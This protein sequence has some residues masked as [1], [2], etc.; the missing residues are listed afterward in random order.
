MLRRRTFSPSPEETRK[1]WRRSSRRGPAGRPSADSRGW[2]SCC[3]QPC[4][5]TC[6]AVDRGDHRRGRRG[7]LGCRRHGRCPGDRSRGAGAGDRADRSERRGAI[8]VADLTAAAVANGVKSLAA[9]DASVIADGDASGLDDYRSCANA[10]LAR[11]SRF[12]PRRSDS[13]RRAPTPSWR[14]S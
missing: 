4:G 3:Q 13:P 2:A 6:I 5:D 9:R 10:G 12:G 14:C 7:R 1:V 11:P 8:P